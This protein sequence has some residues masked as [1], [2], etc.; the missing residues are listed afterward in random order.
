MRATSTSTTYRKQIYYD[1]S[2][3]HADLGTKRKGCTLLVDRPDA[4]KLLNVNEPL[5]VLDPPV[6]DR[7]L[8][9]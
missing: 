3:R 4:E 6:P 5:F 1:E 8:L 7:P 9:L 2:D